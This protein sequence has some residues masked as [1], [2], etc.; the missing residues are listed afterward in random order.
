MISQFTAEV[1]FIT[2][3]VRA[4]AL[5]AFELFPISTTPAL[6]V[7]QH[8]PCNVPAFLTTDA[9]QLS[10]ISRFHGTRLLEMKGVR[11]KSQTQRWGNVSK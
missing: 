11:V 3:Q 7:I 1:L 2:P 8:F 4:L 9:I 5:C 6:K 10:V